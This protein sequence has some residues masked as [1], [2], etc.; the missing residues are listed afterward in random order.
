MSFSERGRGTSVPRHE[1]VE[2]LL[3][4]HPGEKDP[5]QIIRRLAREKVAYAKSNGWS[6]PP[7]CPKQFVSLFGIHCKEVDHDID[8]DGRILPYPDGRLWIEYRSGRMPERQRFTIFHEFAHTLFPDYCSFV[9]QHH[10]PEI[11]RRDPNRQFEFLCDL[12]AAEMLLPV[13]NIR[14]DFG[15][16]KRLEFEAIHQLRERYQASID[17]TTYRLIELAET[18]P[19]AAVFL[20]DVKGSHKSSG[21]LWVNNASHSPAFKGFI[22]PGTTPPRDSVAL[23]CYQN[24]TATTNAVRETWWINGKPRTWLA[25][26]TRLPLIP[27]NPSYAKVVV[28]L[29]SLSARAR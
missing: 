18:L 12:G 17:A 9:P 1:S 6:G 19:C 16:L 4:A 28:L 29:R 10:T 22:K 15:S 8:G 23:H 2:A 13:E 5:K 3:A 26:A 7:F 20:T 11:R 24:G 25:Q 21:P 27:D 14:E